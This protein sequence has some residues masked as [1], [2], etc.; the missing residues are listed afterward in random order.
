MLAL[1]QGLAGPPVGGAPV[2]LSVPSSEP[3]LATVVAVILPK[4]PSAPILEAL[5][6]LRGEAY[7]VGFELRLVQAE[8]N[9]ET[10]A[11]L[12]AVARALAP[13]A[14]VA[15]VGGTDTALPSEAENTAPGAPPASMAF[16]SID[17]WFLDPATGKISIGHLT[18]ES[19]AGHRAD[20]VLAVR[21]VDFVRA[22]MF[23]SLVRASA[24]ARAKRRPSVTYQT[25]GRYR[26]AAGLAA[27]G[28]FSGMAA[29]YL[30]TLQFAFALNSWL[31]LSLGVEALGTETRKENSKGSATAKQALIKV[32]VEMALPGWWRF[33]PFA[34]GGAVAYAVS[35]RGEGFGGNVGYNPWGWSSGLFANVGL[36]VVLSRHCVVQFSGGGMALQN[37]PKIRITGA[38]VAATGRPAWLAGALVGVTF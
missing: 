29:A 16:G 28:S 26:L 32:G 21:V 4:T 36:G 24:E 11:Q 27:T 9:V 14:V 25:E 5:Y 15:L 35:V 23:D 37:E 31:R 19:E 6:R 34:E 10:R 20:Q 30:P 13:T 12:A 33:Y 1:L 3:A 17:V 18:V 8:D 22:R 38:E 2:P 7:S